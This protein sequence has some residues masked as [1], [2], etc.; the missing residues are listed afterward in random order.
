MKTLEPEPRMFPCKFL[1]PGKFI[2]YSLPLVAM[3][4]AASTFATGVPVKSRTCYE[5]TFRVRV[6]KGITVEDLPQ[7]AEII[8][9][10]AS[11]SGFLGIGFSRVQWCFADSGGNVIPR[12]Y[13]GASPQILVSHEWQMCRYRFWTP[14]DAARFDIFP[15]A[16][17]RGD[18]VELADLDVREVPSPDTLNFN[19]DFS[20]SAD[21]PW[22]WQMVG[23]A[24]FQKLPSGRAVVNVVE[25][26]ARSDLFLVKPGMHFKV[27]ACGSSPVLP[28]RYAAESTNLRIAFFSTFEE[29]STNRAAGDVVVALKGENSVAERSAIVPAGKNW[30]RLSVW[31]GVLEKVEVTE[32]GK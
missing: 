21:I 27:K 15:Q 3:F 29:A 28:D 23:S 32:E 13:E 6:V 2:M 10:C 12:P 18:K 8:P 4:V 11:R 24:L 26:T 20:A 19:G 30:A 16:G 25:D 31:N 5:A 1:M 17:R 7:L 14:E 22:G 9:I